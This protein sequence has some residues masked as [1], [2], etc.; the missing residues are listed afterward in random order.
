M[1]RAPEYFDLPRPARA[2]YASLLDSLIAALPADF[3]QEQIVELKGKA[4]KRFRKLFDAHQAAVGRPGPST[5]FAAAGRTRSDSEV[6][7]RALDESWTST[8]RG[9]GRRGAHAYAR[10]LTR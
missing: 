3:E 4:L 6:Q 1:N 8:Q 5:L 9:L 7:R 2:E 10:R